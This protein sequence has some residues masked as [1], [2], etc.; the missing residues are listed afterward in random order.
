MQNTKA[1]FWELLMLKT[2]LK[3]LDE[4]QMRKFAEGIVKFGPVEHS[5]TLPKAH[6]FP[7]F[8]RLFSAYIR[9]GYLL[10]GGTFP[11]NDDSLGTSKSRRIF[12]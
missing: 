9:H 1:F 7:D 3:L 4:L 6:D 8:F 12:H 10:G 5:A 2:V 11:K